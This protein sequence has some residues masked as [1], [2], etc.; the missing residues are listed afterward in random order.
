MLM[1]EASVDY[2]SK[3]PFAGMFENVRVFLE[4]ITWIYL[5]REIPEPSA[6]P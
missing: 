5:L 3:V 4:R 1:P 6:M 2:A